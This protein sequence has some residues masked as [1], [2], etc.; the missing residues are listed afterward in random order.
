[1]SDDPNNASNKKNDSIKTSISLGLAFFSIGVFLLLIPK[2]LGNETVSKVIGIILCGFGIA[3]FSTGQKRLSEFG[4]GAF[5]LGIWGSLYYL[6]NTWWLNAFGLLILLLGFYGIF[7]GIFELFRS[8]N[9][10]KAK[11][12]DNKIDIKPILILLTEISAFVFT[13]FQIL[14][15]A[16]VFK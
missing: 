8:I 12:K 3:I 14:S 4:I 1:M 11:Q 15:I 10:K 16:G 7:S 2:Y 9:E 6:V 13:V 5:F